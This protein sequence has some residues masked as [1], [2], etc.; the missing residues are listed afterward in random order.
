MKYMSLDAVNVEL[1]L[2]EAPKEMMPLVSTV[3]EPEALNIKEPKVSREEVYRVLKERL[4]ELEA[5]FPRSIYPNKKEW[6]RKIGWARFKLFGKIKKE[7]M[8]KQ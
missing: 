5:K 8:K 3:G 4:P 1:K 7:L 6:R 2:K